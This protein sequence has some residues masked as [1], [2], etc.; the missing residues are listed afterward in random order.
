M[1]IDHFGEDPENVYQK[2][3]AYI[4]GHDEVGIITS[5]KHFPGHGDTSNDSHKGPP[6]N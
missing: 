1:E 4:E 3:K 2:A 6:R 5:L